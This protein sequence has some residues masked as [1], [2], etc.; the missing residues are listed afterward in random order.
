[1]CRAEVTCQ[2]N[3]LTI[4]HHHPLRTLATLGFA[5]AIAPF[6]AGAK[7][8]SAK[9]SSQS[10]RPWSCSVSRKSRQAS[11]HT[12]CSSHS[13]RRRQQVEADGYPSGNAFQRAPFRRTQRIPSTT[14]RLGTGLGPPFGDAAGSGSTIDSS[15]HCSSLSS[16]WRMSITRFL[17]ME[18]LR[19]RR[20]CFTNSK[21]LRHYQL[22]Q[23]S[24]ETASSHLSNRFGS[25]FGMRL[26]NLRT[27][28]L[29]VLSPSTKRKIADGLQCLTPI[30]RGRGGEK[31]S[32]A[33]WIPMAIHGSE[34]LQPLQLA[35]S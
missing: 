18:H 31:R 6:F 17:A 21:C 19:V 11:S 26:R 7:D 3:S 25:S 32:N 33:N 30:Q 34:L 2:R 15:S 1:T 8:P 4:D 5:D 23:T 16:G 20:R 22:R 9:H 28:S 35:C 12:P 13:A 24:Y 29:L 27:G 14:G 10:R